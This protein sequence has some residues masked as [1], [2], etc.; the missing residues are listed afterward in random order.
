M[1]I[2][3][4]SHTAHEPERLRRPSPLGPR[5]VLVLEDHPDYRHLL[6]VAI[7]RAGHGVATAEDGLA[8]LAYLAQHPKPDLILCD[9][10]MPR[11]DGATFIAAIR[12]RPEWFDIPVVLISAE[13]Q[14]EGIAA[15]LNVAFL[16]KSRFSPLVDLPTELGRHWL[17]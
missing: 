6:T 12:A 8:G 10:R 9:L 2:V 7:K 4:Q 1:G 11:M 17:A 15:G 16:Q 5:M 13:P 14:G 3:P